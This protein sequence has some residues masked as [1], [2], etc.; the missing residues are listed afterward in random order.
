MRKNL[1]I[2]FLAAAFVWPLA[3]QNHDGKDLPVMGVWQW[4]QRSLFDDSYYGVIDKITSETPFDLLVNFMRFPQYEVSSPVPHDK[5]KQMSEYALKKGLRFA[6][7]LDIRNARVAFMERYPDQLQEMLRMLEVEAGTP[8]V[9][10]API[11]LSDHYSGSMMSPHKPVGSHLLR[12]VTYK[13]DPVSSEIDGT[14]VRDITDRCKVLV[15]TAENLTVSLPTDIE[16]GLTVNAI[17]AFDHLY[18]DLFS[19]QILTFQQELIRMYADCSVSGVCKDEWGFPPYFPRYYRTGYTD[20]WYSPNYDAAYRQR[21]GRSLLDDILLIGFPMKGQAAERIA[22][23]NQYTRL[24]YDRN[25]Q[26]ENDFYKT[27]KETFGEDAFVTVH[28]TWWPFPDKIE[29]RKNGLDWWAVKR[30]L[31]QTDEVAPFSARTSLCKKLDSPVWYNMYYKID[32]PMQMWS[33]ALAGG[34]LDYLSYTLLF[35]QYMEAERKIHLLNFISEAP[36][37]CPVAVIFGH[38]GLRNWAADG[39]DD[40]GVQVADAFWRA[41]YPADLIP[42]SEIENGSLK[43]DS[44]GYICYGRQRYQAAVLYQPELENLAVAEFFKD[45]KSTLLYETGPW[46]RDF[47]GQ[48]LD[49][50]NVLPASMQRYED[51]NILIQNALLDLE[52]TGTAKQSE[53]TGILDN[54]YFKLRDFTHASAMPGTTGHSRMLD[55]T[56]LNVAATR[57]VSGDPIHDFDADGHEVKVDAVGVVAVRF[58]DKGKL[59]AMAAGGLKSFKAGGLSIN[60]PERVNVALKKGTD[61]RWHGSIQQEEI[62]A[63]LTKIT[64]D[65]KIVK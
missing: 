23:I 53:A 33:S 36:L 2:A 25:V 42:S 20:F 37:D 7:D 61:G 6:P 28:S 59:V 43:V 45:V 52:K 27:V 51:Y 3:A 63:A 12:V 34:R 31:A 32:L 50:M 9:V 40:S 46:T 17:M 24:T 21:T 41:G 38:N 22:A 64:G 1:L 13:K 60:L 39:Y 65:W 4:N 8:E 16:P 18:P 62:P 56:Y 44:E 14:T 19:P 15:S 47:N 49:A 58:D 29:A 10:F 35:P 26:I 30:D 5:M 55:G 11:L 54:N 57:D 48:P